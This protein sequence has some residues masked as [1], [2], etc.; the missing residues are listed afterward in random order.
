MRG[1]HRS[2]DEDRAATSLRALSAADPPAPMADSGARRTRTGIA[3]IRR[4]RCWP[5]G[6]SIGRSLMLQAAALLALMVLCAAA[7]AQDQPAVSDVAENERIVFFTTPAHL[8]DDGR[9][10]SVPI[11][12]WIYRPRRNGL[13][14]HLVELALAGLYGLRVSPRTR[15]LFD[16]RVDALLAET[17]G[18]RRIVAR[19]GTHLVSPPPSLGNGH[20]AGSVILSR[21]EAGEQATRVSIEAVLPHGD[22]RSFQG[23]ALLIGETGTSVISDIDDTVKV[24]HV[25]EKRD[26]YDQTFFQPFA[27]V[28]GMAELFRTWEGRG[29]VFHFLSSS[30][31]QLYEPLAD[32]FARAGFPLGTIRLRTASLTDR[33]V[34]NFLSSPAETKPPEIEA[35]LKTFPR[36]RFILVGDSGERDPEVY[37]AIL[38]KHPDQIDKIFIRNL[39]P[40]AA[41][42]RRLLEV[43]AGI[44]E[45]RWQAFSSPSEIDVA[46]H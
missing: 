37:A 15:P 5:T 40:G 44:D 27:P 26:L 16:A 39:T 8:L 13:P 20:F 10:W 31:W 45:R 33:T 23:A 30:P 2:P 29:A 35:L 19:V 34:L 3:A 6:Q 43:F 17:P 11:H 38:G 25:A 9:H 12:G 46:I 36:R 4:W 7:C 28:P 41:G 24:T 14:K 1:V 32:F 22:K 21:E 42:E 18:G